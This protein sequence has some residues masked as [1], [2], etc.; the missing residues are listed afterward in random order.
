MEK[1][2][3]QFCMS[4]NHNMLIVRELTQEELSEVIKPMFGNL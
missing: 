4:G 2:K 1:K 3:Q